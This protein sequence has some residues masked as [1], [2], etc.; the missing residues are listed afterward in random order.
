MLM[1]EVVKLIGDIPYGFEPVVYIIFK[2][3]TALWNGFWTANIIGISVIGIMLL[4]KLINIF[5]KIY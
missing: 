5:R 1:E 4:R 2:S 3:F